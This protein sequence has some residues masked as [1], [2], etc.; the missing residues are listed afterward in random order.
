LKIGDFR[1]YRARDLDLESGHT[2]TA[3]HH[4]SLVDLYLHTEFH[5]NWRN[6]LVDGRTYG[7]ANGHL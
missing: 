2:A 5:W 3:Y 1:L 6:F 4:A 7:W